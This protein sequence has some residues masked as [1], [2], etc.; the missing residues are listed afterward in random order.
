TDLFDPAVPR[1]VT[2]RLSV[3]SE[4]QPYG[5]QMLSLAPTVGTPDITIRCGDLYIVPKADRI[6]V[7]A[8]TEPGRVL[9]A[10]DPDKIAKLRTRAAALCPA[11]GDADM[12]ESWAGTRPGRADH[13]PILGETAL[14]SVFVAA[15]HF[16]NGILLAPLT[17]QF[18]ADLILAQRSHDL[19]QAFSPQ[20]TQP[21]RV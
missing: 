12:I 7:G 15:G 11:L 1:A 10:A 16:R 8:T 20:R 6:I 13:A 14:A 4:I 19:L 9:D 2:D 5:G 18:M 3:L 21:A 17:A